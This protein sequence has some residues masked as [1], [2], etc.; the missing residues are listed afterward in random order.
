[1]VRYAPAVH[2]V[3][4]ASVAGAHAYGDN[5]D[6]LRIA[7]DRLDAAIDRDVSTLLAA[8]GKPAHAGAVTAVLSSWSASARSL[9]DPKLAKG[10]LAKAREAAKP[11]AD[12]RDWWSVGLNAARVVALDLG[13]YAARETAGKV[14]LAGAMEDADRG[15]ER[16]AANAVR[17]FQD[18]NQG[19]EALHLL[20]VLHRGAVVGLSQEGEMNE[21]VGAALDAAG[22]RAKAAL[23]KMRAQ[24]SA[25]SKPS[26]VEL[27]VET[28]RLAHEQGGPRRV[29]DDPKARR[30]FADALVS[31]ASRYPAELSL[32]ATITSGIGTYESSPNEAKRWFRAAADMASEANP[33]NIPYLPRLVEAAVMHHAGDTRGALAAVDDVLAHGKEARI[34]K[35]PHE[36]DALLPFRAWAAES[37]GDH[38]AADQ[39]LRTY[40]ER[41]DVFS[42]RAK[43]QCRLASYRPT[44]IFTANASQRFG[45]IFFQGEVP[46]GSLQSGL[47]YGASRTEDRLVCLATPELG[48]RP[49]V[50]LVTH[51]TR[52]VYAFHAGQERAAHEHLARAVRIARRL[53]FGDD[54]TVGVGDRILHDI[55]KK[56]IE[57]PPIIWASAV[58][59]ARGHIAAADVL[60]ELVR[61]ASAGERQRE[62]VPVLREDPKPPSELVDLGYGSA[63]PWIRAAWA[64]GLDEDAAALRTVPRV[65]KDASGL[66]PWQ[67]QL[68]AA[69]VEPSLASRLRVGA[70]R[71]PLQKVLVRRVRGRLDRRAGRKAGPISLAGA[72]ALADA[73]LGLELVPEVL[74]A[75]SHARQKKDRATATN[76]A[77]LALASVTA[78]DLPLARADLLLGLQSRWPQRAETRAWADAV[79]QVHD[80]MPGC[81]EASEEVAALHQAATILGRERAFAP[82][83]PMLERLKML[84][85]RALDEDHPQAVLFAAAA[86]GVRALQ[87][88]DVAAEGK[89]LAEAAS[90]DRLEPRVRA[91]IDAWASGRDGKAEADE[92]LSN[93]PAL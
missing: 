43:L 91:L 87:G 47:G 72:K 18:G 25:S 58:A 9:V 75:I 73:G 26:F 29:L 64:A 54:V 55:A 13:A 86:L 2:L 36:V 16:L 20:P 56:E 33:R 74:Y 84:M 4:L 30:A 44:I 24:G 32:I 83:A 23:R 61:V 7:L 28:L 12:E 46:T 80:A 53:R 59:R 17:D 81:Y 88:Q 38:E 62:L 14:Q 41:L 45:R 22:H 1:L 21:R 63:G 70:M 82:M 39:A 79:A 19:L 71:D 92:L 89:A 42:G 57:R 67:W 76:L 85:Q 77:A 3:A 11:G 68:L 35:A 65:G 8:H 37:L 49:D 52:A 27:L 69:Q 51:A 6:R 90:T 50:Q 60:D 40:L 34:C 15:L 10:V 93:L 48:I 78:D 31:R 5:P 66:E